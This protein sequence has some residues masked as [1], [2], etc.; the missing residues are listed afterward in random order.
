MLITVPANPGFRDRWPW[1]L[2]VGLTVVVVVGVATA[3]LAWS[4]DD[5][6]VADAHYK[7]DL[8]INRQLKR[9]RRGEAFGLGAMLE[10]MPDSD[11][12]LPN[13]GLAA[14]S[15][16]SGRRLVSVETYAGRLLTEEEG[17]AAHEVRLG[18]ARAVD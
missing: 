3:W 11:A 10:V 13:S 17:G 5:G 14:A 16:P 4:T 9:S 12:R 18:T 1:L 15:L 7:R 8:V 2:M 6:A